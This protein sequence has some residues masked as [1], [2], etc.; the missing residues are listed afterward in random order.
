MRD[1]FQG[2]RCSEVFPSALTHPGQ[3]VY[4][5]T[6]PVHHGGQLVCRTYTVQ[7]VRQIMWT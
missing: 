3:S 1:S 6:D 5:S 7:A 2:L 4:I